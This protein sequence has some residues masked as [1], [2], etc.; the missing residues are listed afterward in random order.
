MQRSKQQAMMF[1][2]G[3]VLVGGV[4]GF[5]ADRVLRHQRFA[6][7]YGPRARYYDELGVSGSQRMILDSILDESSCAVLAAQRPIRPQL[8]SIRKHFTDEMRATLTPEQRAKDDAH[9]AEVKAART[10]AA[11]D[12]PRRPCSTR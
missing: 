8:D 2:L 1:L 11:K 6:S 10:Q 5:S 4:L 12:N 7:D 3:A 9:R